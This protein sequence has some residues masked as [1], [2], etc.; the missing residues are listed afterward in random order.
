MLLQD[1]EEVLEE[2][3]LFVARAGPNRRDERRAIVSLRRR[4][5]LRSG[6][7][8]VSRPSGKLF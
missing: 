1:G 6:C 8:S 7:F 2:V 5:R 3:E 4:L